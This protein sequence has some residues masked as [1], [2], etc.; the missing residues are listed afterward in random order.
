MFYK[1]SDSEEKAAARW[2]T[3]LFLFAVFVAS[4][5]VALADSWVPP[6]IRTYYSQDQGVRFTVTPR[7]IQSPLAYFDGKVKNE[8]QAGQ[9]PGG[10]PFARGV[11][12]QKNGD[13][14]WVTLWDKQLV[15]DVSPVN[16]VV[17]NSGRSVVT[18]D[19]WHSMGWGDDAVVIYGEGGKLVRSF[20][21]TDLLPDYYFKALPRSVSSIWWSGEHR[22][23]DKEDLLVL[24]VVVPNENNDTVENRGYVELPV[25][26]AGGEV[27]PAS[28]ADW[29]KARLIARNIAAERQ[30]EEDKWNAW[31]RSP[32][33]APKT[34]E[35]RD[36]PPYLHEVFSRLD[37]DWKAA[38]SSIE[39]DPAEIVLPSTGSPGWMSDPD[40]LKLVFLE[41]KEPHVILIAS[42][43][44]KDGFVKTLTPILAK[45][46]AGAFKG[47]RIYVVCTPD[48]RARV[49]ALFALTGASFIHVDPAVGIPQR[50]ERLKEAG[51]EP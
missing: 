34:T 20:A 46:K 5:T 48:D 22:I 13:G 16:A 47:W 32:L 12:E 44:D 42:P 10:S 33:V 2:L 18:F 29:D 21:L 39:K 23:A 40:Y 19:N 6:T 25:R 15:N 51:L 27:L 26:L 45:A 49:A 50:P 38:Q 41:W 11:L 17:A 35:E 37:P 36:W 30:K 43:G 14:R 4:Q 8:K 3:L 24:S 9:K 7:G 31:L 28:G 1:M